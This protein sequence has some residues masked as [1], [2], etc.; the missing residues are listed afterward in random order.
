MQKM[1][2]TQEIIMFLNQKLDYTILGYRSLVKEIEHFRE[3]FKRKEIVTFLN[4][5]QEYANERFADE[6]ILHK[7]R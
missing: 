2:N 6:S 1:E 3:Q 7:T 5:T 4:K